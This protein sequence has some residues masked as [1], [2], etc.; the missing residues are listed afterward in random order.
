M[1]VHHLLKEED[2]RVICPYCKESLKE[3]EW[4]SHFELEHHYKTTDCKCGKTI[5]IK[6]DFHG[7]GNDEWNKKSLEKVIEEKN[8]I[9]N[10]KG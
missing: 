7:S 2:L 8:A 9:N 5:S 1:C 3:K 4:K 6:V 10:T